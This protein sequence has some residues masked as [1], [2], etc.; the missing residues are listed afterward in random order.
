MS[1]RSLLS[2]AVGL[3]LDGAVVRD[4]RIALGGVAAKPWRLRAAEG[5]L[6]G[7]PFASA[8]LEAAT[9]TALR[10]ARPRQDNAFKVELVAR[11][12]LC[13]F[14]LLGASA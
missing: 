6:L 3:E 12:V 13:A 14:A 5:A 7:Q 10:A 4:V 11:T 1:S 8:T 2:A 9:R